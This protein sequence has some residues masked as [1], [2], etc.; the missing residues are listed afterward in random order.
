MGKRGLK[1]RFLD[2]ACPNEQWT[3]F[4]VA[5]KGNVACCGTYVNSTGK[6]SKYICHTCGTRFCDR[7]NTVFYDFRTSEDKA[8]LAL[9]MVNKG[10]SILRIPDVLKS[11]LKVPWARK[12]SG[13]TLLGF[14]DSP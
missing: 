10:M 11:Q 12:G 7:T 1:P 2:M 9:D 4:G 5:W 13:F 14:S 8:R 6:V 3:H